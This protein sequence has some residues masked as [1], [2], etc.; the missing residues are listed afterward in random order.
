MT[1]YIDQHRGRFGVEPIC[2]TLGVSAS[3]YYHRA[4]GERSQRVVEDE[5]L[6]AVIRKVHKDNYSAYG[7]RRMWKALH[8]A[9]ERVARCRVQRLMAANGIVGA[10]RRGKPWRTTKPDPD[11]VRPRDLVKRDFTAD[12]PNRLWVGDFTYLRCWEGVV[13]FSFV[14]DVFSRMIVGWQLSANMRRTLVLDALRMAIG[15]REPGADFQLICHTDAGS[16]YTSF[17]YTQE[18]DDRE[19]LRS[20]GTVGDA[21]DNAMAESFVDTFKTELVADRVWRTRNQFE[22]ETVEW[23]GWYNHRRLHESLGD[24]PPVEY[25]ALH[26]GGIGT[27]SEDETVRALLASVSEGLTQRPL[28]LVGAEIAGERPLDSVIVTVNGTLL[29]QAAPKVVQ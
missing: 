13:Y 21:Y 18:L 7:Y 5:R 2:R 12:A 23:I 14:L 20:I 1:R 19:V 29:A 8:R 24:I 15:T 16:Q 27:F 10:K 26:T 17:D 4:A 9:G 11:A 22:L 3:A 28:E 25:E 6:L